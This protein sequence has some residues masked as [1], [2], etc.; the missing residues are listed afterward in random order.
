MSINISLYQLEEH[1]FYPFVKDCLD[2][3]GLRP[4]TITFE[5][6]E[7]Q[8]V[9]DWEF[10]NRQFNQFHQLGIKIAMDDFGTGYSSLGFLKNFSCNLIKIDRLFVQDILTGEFDQNLVK[11]TIMLCHSIGMEVC[12]EGVEE[13]EAYIFLRDE[14]KAD[15]IQGFYFGR[16]ERKQVFLRRLKSLKR[17]TG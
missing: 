14:C 6:T 7:S 5:L 2:R 17:K 13:E 3:Y 10:V 1:M 11:Y 12:I 15:I 16:P 4:E 8:S 9:S